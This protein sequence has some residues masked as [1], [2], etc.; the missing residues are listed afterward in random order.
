MAQFAIW[1]DY[2]IFRPNATLEDVLVIFESDFYCVANNCIKYLD[3]V[4]QHQYTDI[5]Y[6]GYCYLYHKSPNSVPPNCL[7]A[8][9]I[10]C[11]A[12]RKLRDLLDPCGQGVDSQLSYWGSQA[13]YFTWDYMADQDYTYNNTLFDYVMKSNILAFDYDDNSGGMFRQI[14]NITHSREK[15]MSRKSSGY[16]PSNTPPTNN[17]LLRRRSV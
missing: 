7:H 2:C 11:G 1:Q 15:A 13:G 5:F 12:A 8:Y 9:S 10:K 4:I 14:K 16:I 6:L 17:N 3:Y